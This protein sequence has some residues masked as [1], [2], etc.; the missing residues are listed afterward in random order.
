MLERLERI[1]ELEIELEKA[2]KGLLDDLVDML[3]LDDLGD[4]PNTPKNNTLEK[5]MELVDNYQ[6][7]GYYE[8]LKDAIKEYKKL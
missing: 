2:N 3:D 6:V 1:L 4:L 8:D 7:M 5:V